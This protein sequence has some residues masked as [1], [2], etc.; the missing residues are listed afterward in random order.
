MARRHHSRNK[1]LQT[2]TFG[3]VNRRTIKT[4]KR[5]LQTERK[6]IGAVQNRILM[7]WT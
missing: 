2:K 4:G 1:R 7:D 5:R 6:Q 3:G